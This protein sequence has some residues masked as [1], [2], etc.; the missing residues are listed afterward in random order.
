MLRRPG[1][2]CRGS[3]DIELRRG[4]L[5]RCRRDGAASTRRRDAGAVNHVPEPDARFADVTLVLKTGR[6]RV[7]IAIWFR[8]IGRLPPAEWVTCGSDSRRR[9]WA[10]ALDAGFVA[11]MVV[12]LPPDAPSKGP[13]DSSSSTGANHAPATK[14]TTTPPG[15]LEEHK[16]CSQW[17]QQ[18]KSS[19][20][21]RGEGT[22]RDPLK[23]RTSRRPSSA[24]GYRSSP[25]RKCPA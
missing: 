19:P 7:L 14:H 21:R 3:T 16:G 15:Q 9:M 2:G 5:E 1:I 12:V 18:L 10:G 24:Q 13:L 11:I 4:E 6:T 22:C 17:R 23:A 20:L 25:S 8:T